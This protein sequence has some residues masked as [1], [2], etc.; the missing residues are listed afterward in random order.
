MY[1]SE[2][3]QWNPTAFIP[4]IF[5]IAAVFLPVFAAWRLKI[6]NLML[7]TL[8]CGV[9]SFFI[10]PWFVGIYFLYKNLDKNRQPLF[11]PYVYGLFWLVLMLV[12]LLFPY[13]SLSVLS[14]SGAKTFLLMI[15]NTD[16]TPFA[17]YIIFFL[18]MGFA[19]SIASFFLKKAKL[20]I[21]QYI[22]LTLVNLSYAFMN[23]AFFG[24]NN[25][26]SAVAGLGSFLLTLLCLAA[27]VAMYYVTWQTV[28]PGH[29]TVSEP[30][31]P[32]EPL[33]QINKKRAEELKNQAAQQA[34]AVRDAVQQSLRSI[35]KPSLVIHCKSGEYAGASFSL[36]QG[37][38]LR[39]GT[40]PQHANLVLHGPEISRR[41]CTIS[42]PDKPNTVRIL[43]TS[44]NGTYLTNGTRLPQNLAADFPLPCSIL[45]G[46]A[47]QM[48]EI[49]R[50]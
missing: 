2:T 42:C 25:L 38:E 30:S 24:W 10:I 3:I 12:Y 43:D 47:P 15:A 39:I 18:V 28:F 17:P 7:I 37:E 1:M 21:W 14:L 16:S 50:R 44:S 32:H 8:V 34:A 40:D 36:E 45:F 19:A 6:K 31:E 27:T 29:S 46:D 13:L 49:T 48:F 4:F 22:F 23:L 20:L 9:F 41:H 5:V 35:R 33:I 11:K 26:L